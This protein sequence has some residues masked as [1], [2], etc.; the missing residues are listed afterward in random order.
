MIVCGIDVSKQWLDAHFAGTDKRLPNDVSGFKAIAR[1]AKG[2]E[3]FVMEASG[4][5]HQDLADW[6][7]E[8]GRKVCV[9]NPART[10]SFARALGL[11]NKT[12]RVDARAL[13]LFG[14]RFELPLYEPPSPQERELRT[15]SRHREDLVREVAA[16]R[17]RLQETAAHDLALEHRRELLKLLLAQLK[18]CKARLRAL[19][20]QPGLKE[21]Y[22]LLLSVPGVGEG[23]AATILAECSP[24]A[25]SGA[26]QLAA[27]AGVCPREMVSGSSVRGRTR[28]CKRGNPRLRRAL[29]MPAMAAIR[30]AGAFQD[31]YERLLA[32]GKSR[33]AALAAVMHKLL[34]VA[35]GVLKH[36]Q[37]YAPSAPL[38]Q[39]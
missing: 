2:A 29:Y 31:L 32:K 20:G 35:Y 13:A 7:C 28:L 6:L 34:R 21:R 15:L 9:A 19:L 17:V 22:E 3:L 12:D 5:Y 30:L 36:R 11:R 24:E 26:K 10:A 14:A 27:Y 1:L 4:S 25:F 23:L 18:A 33:M 38:A 16:C 37:P 39:L 8:S